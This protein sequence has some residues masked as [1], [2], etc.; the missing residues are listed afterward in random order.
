MRGESEERE[1]EQDL[2]RDQEQECVGKE[3]GGKL[4]QFHEPETHCYSIIYGFTAIATDIEILVLVLASG[5]SDRSDPLQ[6]RP[7]V[8][9]VRMPMRCNSAAGD[10]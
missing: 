6:P 4:F 10:I 8:P 1:G 3:S 5:G 2:H 7:F 9:R